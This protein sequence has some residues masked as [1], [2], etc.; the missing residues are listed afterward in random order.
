MLEVLHDRCLL[1]DP[2]L[3]RQRLQVLVGEI[4]GIG[5]RL[6]LYILVVVHFDNFG[7]AFLYAVVSSDLNHHIA[8]VVLDEML[9]ELFSDEEDFGRG[10]E[11]DL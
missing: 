9:P 3:M 2:L 10:T 6:E 1:R 7:E 8:P 11:F 5:L 4:E